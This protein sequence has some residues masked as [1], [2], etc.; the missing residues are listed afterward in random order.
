M[1][2]R[3]VATNRF[4]PKGNWIHCSSYISTL[5]WPRRA[6]RFCLR[7]TQIVRHPTEIVCFAQRSSLNGNC[8][9]RPTLFAQ[10]KLCASPNALP[11]TEI[12]FRPTRFAQRKLCACPTQTLCFAQRNI[13]CNNILFIF[14]ATVVLIVKVTDNC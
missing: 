13:Q 3:E 1:R 7:A 12:V 4:L 2:A 9:L 5:R 8:V 14:S 11:S 10:R 6:F